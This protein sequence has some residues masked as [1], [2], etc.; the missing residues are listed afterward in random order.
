MDGSG[1]GGSSGAE[2][3]QRTYRIGTTLG[4]GSFGKVRIAEHMLTGHKVA[5]KVLNRHKIKSM[6]ME[7]KGKFA[8]IS[9][10]LCTYSLILFFFF[11]K[12]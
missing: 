2:A 4:I 11:F 1:K 7:E 6:G 9:F 3:L 8:M 5:I 10:Y 12:V